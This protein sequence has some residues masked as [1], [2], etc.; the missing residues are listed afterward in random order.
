MSDT[1]SGSEVG[2]AIVDVVVDVVD[3]V[4]VVVVDV[5]VVANDNKFGDDVFAPGEPLRYGDDVVGDPVGVTSILVE[6]VDRVEFSRLGNAEIRFHTGNLSFDD[7]LS[8]GLALLL[9]LEMFAPHSN[10][11]LN[12]THT[13]SS[14]MKR[15]EEHSAG[16]TVCPTKIPA[17]SIS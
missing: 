5:V 6:G 3:V 4:D 10:A 12:G 8:L 13:D 11:P 16:F 2:S 15:R 7:V 1:T 14:E 17:V 9:L